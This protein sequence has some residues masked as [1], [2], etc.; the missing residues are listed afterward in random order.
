MNKCI[1]YGLWTINT[2]HVVG[3]RK[4]GHPSHH[5]GKK[6]TNVY[7]Q[8][9]KLNII[10]HS[11]VGTTLS[12]AGLRGFGFVAFQEHYIGEVGIRGVAIK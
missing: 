4:P 7:L 1:I 6:I 3:W 10:I 11:S 12:W 5:S 8:C 2:D 9:V